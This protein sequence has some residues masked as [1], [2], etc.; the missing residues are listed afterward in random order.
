V[1]VSGEAVMLGVTQG[2]RRGGDAR[3]YEGQ[4]ANGPTG[5]KMILYFF[6]NFN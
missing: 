2:G 6:Q 4:L 1:A 5:P 3:G